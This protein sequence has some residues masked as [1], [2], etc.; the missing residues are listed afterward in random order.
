[1]LSLCLHLVFLQR[2]TQH[3]PNYQ[4]TVSRKQLGIYVVVAVGLAIVE[5]F[6]SYSMSILPGSLY[7]LLKGSDVGCSMLLSYLC[8]HDNKRNA[9]KR[10]SRTQVIAAGLIMTGIVLVFTIDGNDDDTTTKNQLPAI[11]NSSNVTEF[12][13][14]SNGTSSNSN[15]NSNSHPT[16]GTTTTTTPAVAVLICLVGA[17]LN[18]LCSVGTE[19]VLK[20]TLQEEEE[21]QLSE[22]QQQQQPSW[23]HEKHHEEHFHDQETTSTIT[24]LPQ[25]PPSKLF[26]SNAYSMWTSFFS[27]LLLCLPVLFDEFTNHKSNN[28]DASSVASSSNLELSVTYNVGGSTIDSSAD[29]TTDMT[30]TTTT[31]DG[32]SAT[33]INT[34]AVAIGLCLVP[35]ALSRFLERL[36]KHFICVNDSA[37]T[38]SI[39]QAAR[40][41]SGIFII[42]LLFNG[43]EHIDSKGMILGSLVSGVGFAL[44]TKAA[45]A[46]M[47]ASSSD[48]SR[49]AYNKL[50]SSIPDFPPTPCSTPSE[51]IGDGEMIEM[52]KRASQQD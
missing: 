35:L 8:L 18:A 49:H 5:V 3:H 14:T 38:F 21:R 15:S 31:P 9:R 48:T 25:L 42:G 7:M 10:Y 27:F 50:Q 12:N 16:I 6:N 47:R 17:F 36:S 52:P 33:A 29:T 20:Q 22:Q 34:H 51:R 1:M 40:R 32:S 41:W 19:A 24:A 28:N 37:V 44:H 26:L 13:N 45:V 23:Q 11:G 4:Y 39:V 30:T 46:K 2:Q 43:Y